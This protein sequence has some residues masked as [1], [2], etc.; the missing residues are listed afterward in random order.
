MI[1]NSVSAPSR[2]R[3]AWFTSSF[4]NGSQTCVEVKFGDGA[5][6][7]RDSKDRRDTDRPTITVTSPGWFTFLDTLTA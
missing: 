5:V 4:S 2:H 3:N 1:N 7:V 6:L